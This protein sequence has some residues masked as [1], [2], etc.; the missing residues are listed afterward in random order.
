MTAAEPRRGLSKDKVKL[1]LEMD[2]GSDFFGL[3][4]SGGND[5]TSVSITAA[6]L[7]ASAGIAIASLAFFL[8]Q[9]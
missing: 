6:A 3:F 1:A 8:K 5:G 7:L 4:K 2:N 9:R